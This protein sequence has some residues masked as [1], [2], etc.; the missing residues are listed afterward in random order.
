M[1]NSLEKIYDDMND[2]IELCEY[3]GEAVQSEWDDD[4][5]SYYMSVYG[6]HNQSLKD[7]MQKIKDKI[8]KKDKKRK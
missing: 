6:K 3:F 2:Y 7:R 1:S 8:H 5:C 4:T